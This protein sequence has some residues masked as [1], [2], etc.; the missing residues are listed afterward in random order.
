MKPTRMAAALMA[1]AGP[2]LISACG[3]PSTGVVQA[4]DPATGVPRPETQPQGPSVAPPRG[5]APVG[6]AAHSARVYFLAAG[7]LRAVARTSGADGTPATAVR[8][9]LEGPSHAERAEGFTTQLPSLPSEPVVTV[10]GR[11]VTI[12]IDGLK[13]LGDQAV[14]QLVCT[15]AGALPAEGPDPGS[16]EVRIIAASGW[17]AFRTD[18]ACHNAPR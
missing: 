9:L 15:A 7:T 16:A 17:A 14:D 12:E 3:V 5:S 11:M 6:G 8:V 2:L 1:L 10:A 13:S 4:G 18:D